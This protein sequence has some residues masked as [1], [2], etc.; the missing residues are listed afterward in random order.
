MTAHWGIAD[1]VAVEGTDLERASAFR[2]TL[3][4]LESRIKLFTS[5]PIAALDSMTL[6]AQLRE[7][8]KSNI[9]PESA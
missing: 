9:A 6:Q 3:K 4:E 5:L 8:G 2:K 1:P 7:I